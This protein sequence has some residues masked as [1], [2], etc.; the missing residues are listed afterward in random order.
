[1]GELPSGSQWLS[2]VSGG[3]FPNVHEL[4]LQWA[5]KRLPPV[6]GSEAQSHAQGVLGVG[7][8]CLYVL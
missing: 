2:K 4:F 1:M 6:M 3:V 8:E 7:L 5:L